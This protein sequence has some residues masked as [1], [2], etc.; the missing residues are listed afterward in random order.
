MKKILLLLTVLLSIANVLAQKTIENPKTGFSTASYLSISKIEITDSTTVVSFEIAQYSGFKFTI[1]KQ[2]Y[3]KDVANEEKLFIKSAEGVSME[4]GNV[5]PE[6]GTLNYKLIFGKL[7]K[8][9]AKIEY[10]E[11]NE[12]GNWFIYDIALQDLPNPAGIN[13][14]LEGNWYNTEN[15]NWEIGFYDNTIVY[16]SQVWQYEKVVLKKGNGSVSL[17]NKDQ[18]VTLFVKKGK[19]GSYFIGETPKSLIA[20]AN[21]SQNEI[22]KSTNADVAYELPVFKSDSATYSGYIKNYSSQATVKTIA[23]HIDDIIT[24]AQNTHI[25]KLDENGFFSIKLPLYYP[26][27]VWVR[28]FIFNGS[29]YLEPGKTLFHLLGDKEALF[30]GEL[31]KLNVD[32]NKFNPR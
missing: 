4:N 17:T 28:S 22:V 19:E 14:S 5:I 18:K 2:S 15:G 26:H 10:G 31:A 12:G 7:D 1:P 23:I 6:S 27:E 3:I 21:K 32:L 25:A 29:V 8:S 11:A 20:F 24:G 16:K 9:V 30:M 13:K